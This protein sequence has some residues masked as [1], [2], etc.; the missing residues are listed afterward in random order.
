MYGGGWGSTSML[1]SAMFSIT[2]NADGLNNAVTQAN[3]ALN[4]LTAQVA[5]T[6]SAMLGQSMLLR[7]IADA[8]TQPLIKATNEALK[9][10]HQLNEI[11][12]VMLRDGKDAA[13]Q[14]R[15]EILDLS[16][17]MGIELKDATETL[18]SA[19]SAGIPKENVVDF[20][21]SS[22][23]AARAGLTNLESSSQALRTI[24]KA[25]NIDLND[26]SKNYDKLG[27]AVQGAGTAMDT[28]NT[29][30]D[31]LLSTISQTN[32]R[33]Q[34]FANTIG[35]VA[36]V[37]AETGVSVTQLSALYAVLGK[38]L[39]AEEISSGLQN[40][41]RTFT[42]PTAAAKKE[43]ASLNV[44]LGLF[45]DNAVSLS[46]EWMNKQGGPIQAFMK[47]NELL[48]GSQEKWQQVTQRQQGARAASVAFSNNSKDLR[49]ALKRLE[50][51]MGTTNKMA[52]QMTDEFQ[53]VKNITQTLQNIFVQFGS[54]SLGP[55]SKLNTGLAETA[56]RLREFSATIEAVPMMRSSITIGA[57]SIVLGSAALIT[58]NG[59]IGR[60]LLS[61]ALF[62]Y[63]FGVS[64]LAPL[65]ALK[66]SLTGGF[67]VTEKLK[68]IR[69]AFS[70]QF[71]D[72][73]KAAWG[74]VGK[75]VGH[76]EGSTE[77][78]ASEAKVSKL[79]ST[80]ME[81][82]RQHTAVVDDVT[83]NL[84]KQANAAYKAVDE[85]FKE[86]ELL[87]KEAQD[88]LTRGSQVTAEEFKR[89]NT[90]ADSFLRKFKRMGGDVSTLGLNMEEALKETATISKASL[91]SIDKAWN[92]SATQ[93]AFRRAMLS[94]DT[95]SILKLAEAIKANEPKIAVLN[96]MRAALA[97]VGA[98]LSD[99][100]KIS[101]TMKSSVNTTTAEVD[102]FAASIG[103]SEAAFKKAIPE[104]NRALSALIK[105]I[106]PLTKTGAKGSSLG[107][108]A[109]GVVSQ[110]VEQLRDMSNAM[111]D[112]VLQMNNAKQAAADLPMQTSGIT[113]AEYGAKL[114]AEAEANKAR[115]AEIKAAV[116]DLNM[117]MTKM[118]ENTFQLMRGAPETAALSDIAKQ[119]AAQVKAQQELV[120]NAA[121]QRNAARAAFDANLAE[122]QEAVITWNKFINM[123]FERTAVGVWEAL[124]TTAGA[125]KELGGAMIE[126]LFKFNAWIEIFKTVIDLGKSAFG[127][128]KEWY[129]ME[130][131]FSKVRTDLADIV[132]QM[133][134]LKAESG[135]TFEVNI[136]SK[137]D[138]QQ[139]LAIKKM[140]MDIELMWDRFTDHWLLRLIGTSTN[141]LAQALLNT[142]ASIFELAGYLWSTLI[143]NIVDGFIKYLPKMAE[144]LFGKAGKSFVTSLLPSDESVQTLKDHLRGIGDTISTLGNGFSMFA[145]TSNDF[146]KG[147][148]FKD[149][150]DRMFG[151]SSQ[152]LDVQ[153]K[154][155]D[156]L[157]Q[158]STLQTE[159]ASTIEDTQRALYDSTLAGKYP[160][161]LAMTPE[162]KQTFKNDLNQ[163]ID[164]VFGPVKEK[165]G[166]SGKEVADAYVTAVTDQIKSK[167]DDIQRAANLAFFDNLD[168]VK[169]AAQTSGSSVGEVF[170]TALG[171]GVLFAL[172]SGNL[173]QMIS[174]FFGSLIKQAVD[175]TPVGPD[176]N[177]GNFSPDPQTNSGYDPQ[178]NM[179][180]AGGTNGPTRRSTWAWVGEQ[181]KELAYL[182]K[183][184]MIIPGSKA[185]NVKSIPG[186]AGGTPGD[187]SAYSDYTQFIPIQIPMAATGQ[188]GY[189]GAYTGNEELSKKQQE[190][191]SQAGQQ[192]EMMYQQWVQ[193]AQAQRS[194]YQ[195]MI[196]RLRFLG[197]EINRLHDMGAGPESYAGAQQEYEDLLTALNNFKDNF[198]NDRSRQL[199]DYYGVQYTAYNA[200]QLRAMAA[201]QW[202]TAFE[203]DLTPELYT[204]MTGQYRPKTEADAVALKQEGFGGNFAAVQKLQEFEQTYAAQL[205]QARATVPP[206]TLAAT[207]N[208]TTPQGRL[209]Y[210][211]ALLAAAGIDISANGF[212]TQ[213]AI[214]TLMQQYGPQ[215][216]QGYQSMTPAMR[217]QFDAATQTPR[218]KLNGMKWLLGQMGIDANKVLKRVKGGYSAS[219]N[220]SSGMKKEDMLQQYGPVLSILY[221][222]LN[223]KQQAAF[224]AQFNESDSSAVSAMNTLLT[225]LGNRAL[226]DFLASNGDL[227]KVAM[228]RLSPQQ[229]RWLSQMS[230]PADVLL[231]LLQLIGNVMDPTKSASPLNIYGKLPPIPT[232]MRVEPGGFGDNTIA[233]MD[234]SAIY[235][236]LSAQ[237]VANGAAIVGTSN[238]SISSFR[239]DPMAIA[240]QFRSIG[241]KSRFAPAV[242]IYNQM[243]EI[244]KRSGALPK[245]GNP[246]DAGLLFHK[247]QPTDR[248]GKP[249]GS[250][251]Y[252]VTSTPYGVSKSDALVLA[253][254]QD[255]LMAILAASLE[256]EKTYAKANPNAT[257]PAL[258]SPKQNTQP[259]VVTREGGT[260]WEISPTTGKVSFKNIKGD[261]FAAKANLYAFIRRYEREII[262][263]W[264]KLTPE[265]QNAFYQSAVNASTT[266]ASMKALLKMF[267]ISTSSNISTAGVTN[268]QAD[269][270]DKTISDMLSKTPTDSAGMTSEQTIQATTGVSE[271]TMVASAMQNMTGSP[272]GRSRTITPSGNASSAVR[273]FPGV[274]M[275]IAKPAVVTPASTGG[276]TAGSSYTS[277]SSS[278]NS[279]L[280]QATRDE[281]NKGTTTGG[282][283]KGTFQRIG[284]NGL[285]IPREIPTEQV[286]INQDGA[287]VGHP[288]D[289]EKTPDVAIDGRI[290]KPRAIETIP[291]N[292]TETRNVPYYWLPEQMRKNGAGVAKDV[293]DFYKWFWYLDDE[294]RYNLLVNLVGAEK[295]DK[296]DFSYSPYAMATFI[297]NQLRKGNILEASRYKFLSSHIFDVSKKAD[298]T[299]NNPS[300]AR[301]LAK[302]KKVNY[303][304]DYK[305]NGSG[306]DKVSVREAYVAPDTYVNANGDTVPVDNTDPVPGDLNSE[307]M[308][309]SDKN[310]PMSSGGGSSALR[311]KGTP[312]G[313]APAVN[314]LDSPWLNA[315]FQ[316]KGVTPASLLPGAS[317]ALTSFPAAMV[318]SAA[319]TTKA[320]SAPGVTVNLNIANVR[321]D[322][323]V[324]S[325][326]MEVVTQ[327]KRQDFRRRK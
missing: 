80:L 277:P 160:L 209:Q 243:V 35:D 233:S 261:S 2:G 313:S 241:A 307:G 28:F 323:Q 182:P 66:N 37:A 24:I 5:R 303:R 247:F 228:G 183:G 200:G 231:A 301:E 249:S 211:K 248:N 253:R 13:Q 4:R 44:A 99:L 266:L 218:G 48:G 306:F 102:A 34:D 71:G 263:C 270:V 46:K 118:E 25:Y 318:T 68:E 175:S 137:V 109:N 322:E 64:I 224:D 93:S 65:N 125:F 159:I 146:F 314:P 186:F 32:F 312:G 297:Y 84:R 57:G 108:E 295:A 138:E 63:E 14:Y 117:Q 272:N 148:A 256:E 157:K 325:L 26:A 285:P 215:L 309:P 235:P 197:E 53:Q 140:F 234:A 56:K 149:G 232:A 287:V 227:I 52:A 139:A 202:K 206:E 304:T 327:V 54:V 265:Q 220:F 79:M 36:A 291:G 61:M 158:Q 124:K 212:E 264:N 251:Q 116:I 130:V 298:G 214:D 129:N 16:N 106:N 305:W 242:P 122:A 105:L 236:S 88:I 163:Q 239:G 6:G 166:A 47:L 192:W 134:S 257:K 271:P 27:V 74:R 104:Y 193:N 282:T 133:N 20:L 154:I 3:A 221:N 316:N 279:D 219:N 167:Q 82:R 281:S 223:P 38:Q 8:M 103:K 283:S 114:A 31:T 144:T 87:K 308:P 225:E 199:A 280:A 245:S 240:K 107:L 67:S 217:N 143:P 83:N 126:G 89:L 62:R 185:K 181:G 151:A 275:D 12:S 73:Y 189:E 311:K 262:A 319:G 81:L 75:G 98:P 77:L 195:A 7:P 155:L 19:I 174:G 161:F 127:W 18:Y 123:T 204:Q 96:R 72:D 169:E 184:S 141:M 286:V 191:L 15:K 260:Q 153:N 94:G 1:G 29:I 45:G 78:L 237:D 292:R 296:L 226:Q 276:Y 21:K 302:A 9:F 321:S 250:A 293:S 190:L 95:E 288:G 162:E 33:Y 152:T 168:T 90:V 180:F 110:T 85:F 177:A 320:V 60:L 216:E 10:Q 135:T 59:V 172:K 171:D 188:Q 128:I 252:D 17:A 187:L 210:D 290:P 258:L 244:L 273:G 41:F 324:R 268:T 170:G 58:L 173:L 55:N 246:L 156:N 120:M 30:N 51:P 259:P 205:A 101:D 179:G 70:G 86:S 43:I 22:A 269:S 201:Q 115:I 294:R 165:V 91:E 229:Q 131:H 289:L 194:M 42:R 222:Y 111:G 284:A 203:S 23:T 317:K 267:G 92:L 150:L 11:S 97:N 299:Y 196:D 208:Y 132:K 40:L 145:Q 147:N 207:S 121:L 274:P 238:G 198:I 50:D 326:A 230:K 119:A 142:V 112:I 254:L 176:P 136:K 255:E 39:R 178:V 213:Q 164:E 100:V 300:D 315:M 278:R 76:I 113:S 69:S 310:V 49:E